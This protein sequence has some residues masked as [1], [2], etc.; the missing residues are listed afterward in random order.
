MTPAAF[1]APRTVAGLIGVWRMRAPVASKKA[2]A[3]A[4]AIAAVGGSP[5]PVSSQ[6]WL[7]AL[8]LPWLTSMFSPP[9]PR[10]GLTVVYW[11]GWTLTS[12]TLG[13]SAKRR[14]G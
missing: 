3:I 6:F 7:N 2:F 13:V 11:P 10:S 1:R 9:F 14:I 12:V 8:V 4:P 5:D